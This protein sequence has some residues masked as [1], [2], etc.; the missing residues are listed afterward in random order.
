MISEPEA[1]ASLY[2]SLRDQTFT[3]EQFDQYLD[4]YLRTRASE[5]RSVEAAWAPADQA[6]TDAIRVDRLSV[7]GALADREANPELAAFA[8]VMSADYTEARLTVKSMK[9]KDRAVLAFWT[10]ELAGVVMAVQTGEERY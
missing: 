8:A 7:S 3:R 6:V 10:E 2:N 9:P 4:A 5:A 1:R